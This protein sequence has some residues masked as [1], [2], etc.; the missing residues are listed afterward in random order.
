MGWNDSKTKTLRRASVTIATQV[1]FDKFYNSQLVVRIALPKVFRAAHWLSFIHTV[2]RRFIDISTDWMI[3]LVSLFSSNRLLLSQAW[4][5]IQRVHFCYILLYYFIPEM[6]HASKSNITEYQMQLPTNFGLSPSPYVSAKLA[7]THTFK[8]A[9]SKLPFWAGLRM[10][11]HNWSYI[12]L[13]GNFVSKPIKKQ[14]P[15]AFNLSLF[16]IF[17][18]N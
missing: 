15:I 16:E 12:S 14:T 1:P 4:D 11:L 7:A 6:H 2:P 9:G 10:G 3:L 8:K 13:L 5:F 17:Q 18:T